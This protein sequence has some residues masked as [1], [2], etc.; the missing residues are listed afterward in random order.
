MKNLVLAALVLITA[1]CATHPKSVSLFTPMIVPEG[2]AVVYIYKAKTYGKAIWGIEANGE[3][4][5]IISKANYF[6]YVAEP[7][8]EIQLV[9][10][11]KPR[12]GNM[13]FAH[14]EP[15]NRITI[16][17]KPGDRRYIKIAGA[18]NP[19]FVEVREEEALQE[20]RECSLVATY[21]AD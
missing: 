6:P 1:G 7:H 21:V 8:Q 11:M 4:I 9:S 13:I 5:A 17:I 3:P 15:R 2:K 14:I 12:V 10:K 16:N 19:E 20:L 18:L